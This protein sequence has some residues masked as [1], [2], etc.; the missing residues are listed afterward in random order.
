MTLLVE[1]PPGCEGERRYAV[2][3]VFGDLLG[4]E[5]RVA[6]GAGP[7]VRITVPNAAGEVRVADELFG[8]VDT[9]WS[10]RRWLPAR[11]LERWDTAD[12]GTAA[13]LVR[14]T[15]PVLFGRRLGNGSYLEVDQATTTLGLDVFGSAFLLLS[16]YEELVGSERDSHDRFPGAAS[17]AAREG[18]LDRPLVDEY[19]ELLWD[20]LQRR[21]PGLA[22]APRLYQL[23]LSHDVDLPR[24]SGTGLVGLAK[25]AVADVVRRREPWLAVRRLRAYPA[26]RKG[27]VPADPM[28]SFDLIMDISERC[29]LQSAFY[30]IPTAGARAVDAPYGL[31]EDW[32]RSLLRRIHGRG[33]EIGLHASYDT[34]RDA[35]QTRREF[36][37]LCQTAER[38]GIVQEEWG[39]RQHFLRWDAAHTWRNWEEAGL[40][41]DSSLT[42]HDR[43]GFRSGTSHEHRVFDLRARRALRLRERPVVAMDATLKG[44][45]GLSDAEIIDEVTTLA[46]RCRMFDG[47]MGLLWHNHN[48][49]SSADQRTYRALV[50]ALS[51]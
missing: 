42:F 28:N 24:S 48:L 23:W 37:L 26:A 51:P 15:V 38:E 25:W 27:L 19:V 14:P 39:G 49:A 33:H 10:D 16:R 41:Y 45:M 21:W 11:P 7:D 40:A 13:R 47:T 29:G 31:D 22:R 32:T 50:E 18:F 1:V 17:I 9:D 3:V 30:F 34:Y 2:E 8:R 4:V 36:E 5:H 12:A 43:A 35:V 46:G 44:Y 20:V 6:A